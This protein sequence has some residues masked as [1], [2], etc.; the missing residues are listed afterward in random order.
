MDNQ[1]IIAHNYEAAVLKIEEEWLIK[2]YAKWYEHITALPEHLQITYLIV[3]MD[4]QVFNGGFDQ[5]FV[6]GYGLF[7]TETI[8]A[9]I[10]IGAKQKANLLEKAFKRINKDNDSD[11]VFRRRIF[12][13]EILALFNDEKLEIFLEKLDDAYYE[14]SEEIDELLATYLQGK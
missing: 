7:A 13:K 10:K 3:L 14:S 5:Y 9:L 1:E 6:N 11:P 8:R 12:N 2:D 4:N